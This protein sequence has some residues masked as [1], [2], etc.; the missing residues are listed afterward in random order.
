MTIWRYLISNFLYVGKM[1]VGKKKKKKKG[2]S[3]EPV[4]IAM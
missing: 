3:Q 4:C 1:L 2:L